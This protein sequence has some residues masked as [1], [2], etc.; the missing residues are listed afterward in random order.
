MVTVIKSGRVIREGHVSIHLVSV[1][2]VASATA[3][4]SLIEAVS[5]K[6]AA[7]STLR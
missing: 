3:A 1:M 4:A 2:T 7:P 5:A 6:V